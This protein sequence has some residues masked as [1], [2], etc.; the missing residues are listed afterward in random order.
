MLLLVIKMP[1]DLLLSE[2]KDRNVLDCD[3]DGMG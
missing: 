3:R 2:L 1:D